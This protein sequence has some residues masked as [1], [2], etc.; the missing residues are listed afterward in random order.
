MP[1]VFL[2]LHFKTNKIEIIKISLGKNGKETH[3]KPNRTQGQ[4]CKPGPFWANQNNM[5][6]L[7]RKPEGEKEIER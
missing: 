4:Q 5:L 1:P 7:T 2:K 6:N 3:P